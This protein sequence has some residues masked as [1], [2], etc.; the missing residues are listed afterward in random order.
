M[1]GAATVS[2][3]A[4]LSAPVRSNSRTAAPSCV[5]LSSKVAPS[6]LDSMLKEPVVNKPSAHS[7]SVHAARVTAAPTPRTR[8]PA[9][10][11][12]TFLEVFFFASVTDADTLPPQDVGLACLR[13][14]QLVCDKLSVFT[15]NSL[16]A[17]TSVRQGKR[18]I[19]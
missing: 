18:Q 3:G 5:S 17:T 14:T 16:G 1:N 8:P 2:S 4:M 13:V 19:L 9:K 12:L 15:T 10:R 7:W 11:A 6:I